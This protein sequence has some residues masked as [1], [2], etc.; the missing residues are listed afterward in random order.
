MI[1]LGGVKIREFHIYSFRKLV[2]STAHMV[3]GVLKY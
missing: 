2:T 3:K 1:I